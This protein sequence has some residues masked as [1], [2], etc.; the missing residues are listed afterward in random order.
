MVLVLLEDAA[1]GDGV[2]LPQAPEVTAL[3]TRAFLRTLQNYGLIASAEDVLKRVSENSA[4]QRNVSKYMADR[5]GRLG[6][7]ARADW[8][9]PLKLDDD[10][11]GG[12]ASGGPK[13]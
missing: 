4:G 11:S 7:G 12:G 8:K 2:L 1:F 9:S 6:P 13:P 10:G 5:P 3:S